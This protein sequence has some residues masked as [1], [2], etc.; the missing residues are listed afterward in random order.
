MKVG[1]FNFKT[2]KG[3]DVRVYFDSASG[4]ATDVSVEIAGVEV[5]RVSDITL[6]NG[7]ALV[8]LRIHPNVKITRDVKAMIRTRGILGDKFVELIPGSPSAPLIKPGEEIVRT[9]P[10]TD[11]DTLINTLGEV[12][13]D[14]KVLTR[15]FANAL[16]GDR[17]ESSLQ[18][19]VQ[20][21]REMVETLNHTV[22][23]NNADIVSIITNLSD[24]SARLKEIGDANTDDIHSIVQNI[25]KASDNLENLITSVNEISTK[26]NK[27]EGTLG[28][29]VNK[30]ETID[31]LNASLA[32]LREITE[33]INRGEGTLGRL[34]NNEE[35]ITKLDGT[36]SS[37]QEISDKIN[38]GEGTLGRLVNEEE[39]VDN[40]NSTLTSINDYIQ[41]QEMFRTFIDYRGEYLFDSKGTKSY[42]SL[43]LQPK[44]DKYYLFQLVGSSEGKEEVTEITR[45]V[46]GVTTEERI[47]ENERDKLLFSLQIAKRYYDLNLRGGL[48]ESTAGAGIDYY[49]FNDRLALS[50]EAFDFDPD[51]N[52]HLKFKADFTPFKHIYLTSGLDN[53][54]SDEGRES[55]FI[56][57]G[58]NFSDEDI[59]AVLTSIP[60]PK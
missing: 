51:R 42:L 17:G 9:T 40:L 28:R 8:S 23:E 54:I 41:K 7:K 36:L 53:F 27:G 33:K 22:Q 60:L 5:G 39:T 14:I 2:G 18:A 31:S 26:I 15:S 35:T 37:F 47:V 20:N 48:F 57:A 44:Y 34:V 32:A 25:R 13:M 10:T 3:Y 50:V 58:I 29:L 55:F 49:F 4:L 30:D 6:K 59:K 38:K 56:G 46:N 24:F 19:I 21:I 45:T 11:M 52:A 43:K 1:K 16:G 12:A